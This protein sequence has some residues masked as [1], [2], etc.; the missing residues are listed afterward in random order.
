MKPVKCAEE[1]VA[2]HVKPRTD[3]CGLRLP[4][5]RQLLEQSRAMKIA[6]YYVS[7]SVPCPDPGETKVGIFLL[8]SFPPPPLCSICGVNECDLLL[9][10][11]RCYHKLM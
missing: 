11:Q 10:I 8:F 1:Q 7:N 3:A 6:C 5:L 4:T 9:I 2:N